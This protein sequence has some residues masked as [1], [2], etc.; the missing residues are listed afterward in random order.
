MTY[1]PAHSRPEPA[2]RALGTFRYAWRQLVATPALFLVAVVVGLGTLLVTAVPRLVEQVGDDDLREAISIAEPEQR[3]LVIAAQTRVPG[4][5]PRVPFRWFDFESEQIVEAM[6]PV[7]ADLIEDQQFIFDTPDFRTSSFPDE[8]EG[9]FPT[10]LTFR[11]Q[12]ELDRHMTVIEG[13]LPEARRPVSLLRG[14]ECP[15]GDPLDVDDFELDIAVDCRRTDVRVFEVAI[16]AVTAETMGVAVGDQLMLNPNLDDR[17]WFTSFDGG[18]PL[19]S[20]IVSGLVEFT[21]ESDPY[22]FDDNRLHAPTIVENADFRRIFAHAVIAPDQ[23]MA[24]VRAIP[25]VDWDHEWRYFVDGSRIDAADADELIGELRRFDPPKGEL[26]TRLDELL[27]D[28]Q[29]R[30]RLAVQL[31]STGTLGLGVATL[32]SIAVFSMLGAARLRPATVLAR[33]RGSDRALSIVIEALRALILIV[34]AAVVGAGLALWLAG[35]APAST[36][37]LSA[38]AFGVATAGLVTLMGA[39]VAL[40]PLGPLQARRHELARP[41]PRA[42]VGQILVVI[43]AAGA[44]VLVRG[45][46]APDPAAGDPDFDALAAA[47]PALLAVGAGIVALHVT[48]AVVRLLSG[49]SGRSR[50]AVT[51]IALRRLRATAGAATVPVLVIVVATAMAVFGT[52]VQTS[53]RDGQAERSWDV[54]GGDYRIERIIQG[55]TVSSSIDLSSAGLDAIARATRMED[56]SAIGVEGASRPLV[57]VVESGDW[58]EV[59]RGAG[60]DVDALLRLRDPVNGAVPAITSSTWNSADAPAPGTRFD[61][62]GALIDATVEVVANVGSMP[63]LPT[64]EAFIVVDANAVRA[65]DPARSIPLTAIYASGPEGLE[66]RIEDALG[67]LAPITQ[68]TSR[69]DVADEITAFP[70]VNW[71]QRGMLVVSGLAIVVAAAAAATWVGLAA[72]RN[73][74]ELGIVATLGLTRRQAARLVVAEHLPLAAIAVAVGALAGIGATQLLQQSLNVQAF[75]GH[76]ETVDIAVSAQSVVVAA[77]AVAAALALAI[78]TFVVTQRD[79]TVRAMLKIGDET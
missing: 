12:E 39:P 35:D 40:R 59:L 42:V 3:H 36:G 10:F 76:E 52:V 34:P 4:A 58:R 61:I 5:S 67:L 65:N 77:V 1:R 28:F 7:V 19:L 32:V 75:T 6:P 79:A 31:T 15:E 11:Y 70:L 8:Q 60:I 71:T 72:A 38:G 68:V 2:G 33:G 78:T 46:S 74:R 44:V 51:F 25:S 55:G 30:R 27:R 16:S 57:L 53:I 49:L 37:L 22:W 63:S 69:S 48:S 54:V 13:R 45:R 21:D 9:P 26:R 64:G 66:P 62:R 18:P 14:S 43:L 17:L 50:S 20:V 29:E 23:Y 73:R 41:D 56:V 24:L 47:T